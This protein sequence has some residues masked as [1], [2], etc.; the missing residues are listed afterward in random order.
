[1][2]KVICIGRL[3]SNPELR[4][5]VNGEYF[6]GF[7]L[8]VNRIKSDKAD[9]I[10]CICYKKIAESLCQYVQKGDLISIVGSIRTR[11]NDGRKNIEIKVDEITYLNCKGKE[12]SNESFADDIKVPESEVQ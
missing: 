5:T 1:M 12:N 6:S 11:F 8:A 9:F 10:D 4:K 7:T 2:N 3:V